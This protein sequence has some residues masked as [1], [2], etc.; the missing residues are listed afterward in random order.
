MRVDEDALP[1][2]T[3]VAAQSAERT[4]KGRAKR[5]TGILAA[6]FTAQVLTQVLGL[7]AGLILVR[8][9]PVREFA[10][11]T[12]TTSFLT[13]FGFATDL[14][15]TGSLSYFYRRSAQESVEFG[16]YLKAVVGLRRLAF[17]LGGALVAILLPLT[18]RDKGFSPTAGALAT[19]AVLL[20]VWFQIQ[21][22]VAVHVLRLFDRFNATYRAEMAGGA[23]RLVGSA[24]MAL[25]KLLFGWLGVLVSAAAS[26]LT[27]R[28]ANARELLH[29][30][31][32]GWQN[33]ASQRRQ[34]VRFLF[35]TLPSALYF[36]IQSPL[37]VWL[38]ATFGKT[39]NIAQ[40]GALGRLGLIVGLFSNLTGIVLVPRLAQIVDERLYLRRFLQF[41]ALLLSV[42][43]A[44][45]AAAT[46]APHAFL[47]LLGSTYSGLETELRL[48]VAN[49]CLLLLDGYLI[50]VNIARSWTRLQVIGLA[51]LA[52]SQAG[53]VFVLPLQTVVGV[54]TFAVCSSVLVI[55]VQATTAFLGF[56]NPHVVHWPATSTL[57]P[58]SPEPPL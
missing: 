5:W 37:V 52:T 43:L 12:L 2:P 11:Y 54:L 14:G 47:W 58:G 40:V 27:S 31:S 15:M 38:A 7:G 51:L 48:V 50:S 22:S 28:L 57:H 6:Y 36:S 39:E 35:P 32:S 18:A 21:A 8:F 3:A 56:T 41:G 26:A 33:T 25:S 1:L 30:S 20:A 16:P 17:V 42:A 10:L 34:V 19:A 23:L 9:M 53:L 45:F 29:G 4:F 49:S 44:I 24:A 55:L 46:L 13:F